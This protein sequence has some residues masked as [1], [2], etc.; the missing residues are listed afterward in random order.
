ML[1]LIGE[2]MSLIR[3]HRYIC[4]ALCILVCAAAAGGVGLGKLS[5]IETVYSVK[6]GK[7]E[8]FK[9]RDKVTAEKV[10]EDVMDEYTPEGAQVEEIVLDRK[11]STSVAG[12]HKDKVDT[13]VMTEAEA[14]D[15]ILEENATD[16]PLFCV[17]IKAD[18]SDV[19]DV[20]AETE[21]EANDEMFENNTKLVQK[22]VDGSKV[23][24]NRVISVNGAVLNSRNVDTTII[25]DA[26]NKVIHKGTKARPRDTAWADYSG[27]TIGTGNGETIANFAL[28]FVGNPYRYGGTS[29]TNGADCSGFIYAVYH[30]FGYTSVPRVGAQNIGKGVALAEAEP[31]DVVY[32]GH[33]YGM[34]IGGGKIVHAYNSRR[35]ICVTSV[36]DPGR[37]QTIRRLVEP[38]ELE[39]VSADSEEG[40][41]ENAGDSSGSDDDAA[42]SGGGEE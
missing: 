21:Y 36:H 35:G 4:I 28:N 30:H 24:T 19:K 13:E 18:V 10:I 33:H 7:V 2:V 17:T 1:R 40:A 32:Y 20:K 37:I 31:G 23:D 27:T 15:Y 42:D 9:V 3:N 5:Q 38:R 34:Y 14:V 29:L 16:N 22:G 39:E 12:V 25:N 41:G 8:L 26:T 11:I 6:A